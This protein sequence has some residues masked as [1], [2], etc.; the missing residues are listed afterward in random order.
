MDKI[1]VIIGIFYIYY[2]IG[3]LS[4]TNMIRLS[5]GNTHT[6]LASKCYCDHCGATITPFYQMAIISYILC[7]GK[8]RNC[9]SKIPVDALFLEITV[10][11]GM[12][13]ISALLDFSSL[14]VTLSYFYYEIVRVGW[15]L[16]KGRRENGFVKQYIIA[17]LAMIPFYLMTL[18]VALIYQA[19]CI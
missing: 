12:S 11:V 8:C 19:V 3:G 9:K 1:I 17:V 10:M 18:L 7:R 6:V 16:L 15:I 13:V 14:G 5:R 2:H 4:T